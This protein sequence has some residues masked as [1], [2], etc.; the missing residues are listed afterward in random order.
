MKQRLI[1]A[2]AVMRRPQV[3]ILDEPATGLD[4][5]EVRALRQHLTARA[6]AGATILISSHQLAEVQQLASHI[7]VMNH[8]R[9]VI[10]GPLDELLGGAGTYRVRTEDPDQASAVLRAT[11]GVIAATTQGR[12]VVVTAP[13]VPASGL[14]AALVRAG[15]AVT[16]A[17]PAH[18]SLEDAY[19]AITE[20]R[21]HA[22]L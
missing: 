6:A 15:V 19:L 16:G 14:V 9:L 20:G 8:G 11:P 22:A 4:P 10:A 3:L 13:T 2:N 5:A 18:Q 7:V 21:D 12:D 1:L 17:D